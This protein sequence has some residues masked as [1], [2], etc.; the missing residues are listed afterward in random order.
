MKRAALALA[1]LATMFL[2]DCAG[3]FAGS[4]S[5]DRTVQVQTHQ[6]I[7]IAPTGSVHVQNVSGTINIIGWNQPRMQLDAVTYGA[8][9]LDVDKTHIRVHQDGDM[10]DVKTDY[11]RNGIFSPSSSGASV[12]YTLHVP[13]GAAVSVGNVQG[14][15]DVNGISNA[16]TL[17]DVS[18]NIRATNIDGDA[19]ISTTSGDIDAGVLHVGGTRRVDVASVSGSVRLHVPRSSSAQLTAA[20]ISG[21]FTNDFGIS[22][23]HRTVGIAAKGTLGSGDGRIHVATVSGSIA[24]LA[25]K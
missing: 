22:P 23:E 16:V 15:V 5:R 11:D 9:K 19:K 25:Q 6:S 2:T 24:V 4:I 21:D 1:V 13:N 12:D 7:A 3:S 20:S 18:G 10:L 17:A 14:D 8:T